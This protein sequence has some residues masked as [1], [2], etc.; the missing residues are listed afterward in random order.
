MLDQP[1]PCHRIFHGGPAENNDRAYKIE[2]QP[3]KQLGM[4][5]YKKEEAEFI[6]CLF[7]R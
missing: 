7:K 3:K 5:G 2:D 1:I 6:I 4:R